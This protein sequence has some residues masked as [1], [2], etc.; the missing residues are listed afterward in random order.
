[1]TVIEGR[2]PVS[3]RDYHSSRK[4]ALAA[5]SGPLLVSS[6]SVAINGLDVS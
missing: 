5:R 6:A 3:V 2:S 1:M 4:G